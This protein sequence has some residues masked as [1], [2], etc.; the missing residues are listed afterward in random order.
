MLADEA[1]KNLTKGILPFWMKLTDHE[2]GGFYG[3][4][5]YELNVDKKAD[6]G[7]ILV[8]R[9]MW[10]FSQAYIVFRDREYLDTAK[11]AYEYFHGYCYDEEHG[12]LYWST[13]YDG[14]P[15]DTVKHTCV[16][17]YGIYGLV[18][19]Y[20]ASKDIAVLYEAEDLYCF[21][22]DK[23]TDDNGYLEEFDRFF[24]VK[25]NEKLSDMLALGGVYA[26]RTMNTM[27]HLLEAYTELFLENE[28]EDVRD[29]LL[30]LLKIFAD[31]VYNPE[32]ERMEL[33]FDSDYNSLMDMQ[34]Y[35]H[36][37]E[38]AWLIDYAVRVLKTKT[39]K[40]DIVYDNCDINSLFE[41]INDM[42][43]HLR[44]S[45]YKRAFVSDYLVSNSV[46][47]FADDTRVWWVQAE[48]VN[49][50][51]KGYK[52]NPERTEYK[53][54]VVRLLKYIRGHFVDIRSGEWFNE[55]DKHDVPVR[56]E[57]AGQWKCPYHNGRMWLELMKY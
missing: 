51:S 21:I 23:C 54:A 53:D 47:G 40:D 55:L 56:K 31:R 22:E 8:S 57:L 52:Y 14:R 4:V 1:K 12:G 39:D 34:S 6:K 29:K 42:T 28:S 19:Y 43:N 45:V 48:A 41:N 9:I 37:I 26:Y 7:T 18:A 17:A 24:N 10:L 38:C 33:F 50:F 15:S 49:G 11:H 5:D 27:L 2:Y 3:S 44:D 36:D 46:Q 32:K 20:K 25:D 30:S 16:M 13:T 35:G